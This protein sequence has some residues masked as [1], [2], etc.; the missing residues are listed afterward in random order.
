MSIKL[1][2]RAKDRTGMRYGRLLV[3]E[4]IGRNKHSQIIWRCVCDCGNIKDVDAGRL[5]HRTNSW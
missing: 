4:A 2:K 5:G 1:T 3:K